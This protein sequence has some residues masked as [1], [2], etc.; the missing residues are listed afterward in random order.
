MHIV[1][2]TV[3]KMAASAAL[4]GVIGL[5]RELRHKP[6]GLRTNM[7]ISFGSTFFT[8]LSL[9]IAERYHT[10]PGRVAAQIIPGIGFIGAGAIL[11][12]GLSVTGLTTAAT[13]FVVAGIGMGV[14]YGYYGSSAIAT[15]MILASL[16]FLGY[17]ERKLKTK[18]Q[19]YEFSICTPHMAVASQKVMA[20]LD[21]MKVRVDGMNCSREG[22]EHFLRF[23]AHTS[24]ETNAELLK[25][26]LLISELEDIKSS[27]VVEK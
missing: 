19:H 24:P 25:R 23:S 17:M 14:G 20:L 4:G 2:E 1:T 12:E 5:E 7:F 18:Y 3:L 11:R 27:V 26:L 22:E 13:I 9:E 8:M 15:G 16:M 10:D 6:A 21:S